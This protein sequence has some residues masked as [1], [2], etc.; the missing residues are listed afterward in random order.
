LACA[1]V[2]G[3]LYAL[4]RVANILVWRLRWLLF[5]VRK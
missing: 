5:C 2:A 1:G 4:E 3:L